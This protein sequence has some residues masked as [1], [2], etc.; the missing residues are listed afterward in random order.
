MP[1]TSLRPVKSPL[2]PKITSTQGSIESSSPIPART[3]LSGGGTVFMG[4][5]MLVRSSAGGKPRGKACWLRLGSRSTVARMSEHDIGVL[6][7]GVMGRNLALN[8]EEKGFSVGTHDAWPDPIKTMKK[9]GEG[10]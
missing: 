6:G 7:L 8:I 10:K 4:T 2:A 5:R 3:G 1:G 9:E